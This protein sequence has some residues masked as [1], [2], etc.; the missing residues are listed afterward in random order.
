MRYIGYI[1][2]TIVWV[3]AIIGT[4]FKSTKTDAEGRQLYWP[5]VCRS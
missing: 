2:Q 3:L 5:P 1:S 4:L